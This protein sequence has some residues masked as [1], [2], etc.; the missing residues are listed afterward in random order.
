[1]G[2]PTAPV[3]Y[4]W[5]VERFPRLRQSRLSDFDN[6]ALFSL[7]EVTR[8]EG[9]SSHPAARGQVVHRTIARTLREMVAAG[10]DR[11]NVDVA[12][13]YLEQE[14]AQR[15]VAIEPR[16][17]SE[18]SD[19][20][21]LPLSQ[22]AE[23]RITIK[24]WAA[25]TRYTVESF[26][27]IEKRLETTLWY[28]ASPGNPDGPTDKAREDDPDSGEV[29][30]RLVTGQLDLLE[31]EDDEA[32]VV[33]WKDTWD[34]PPE[35]K[36]SEEGYFQQ[37]MYALLVF[38]RYPRVQRVTLREFYLRYASGTVLDRKNQPIKPV[39]EATVDRFNLG[40]IE[41]E[42]RALVERFD[43]SYEHGE[44]LAR[45]A[46]DDPDRARRRAFTPSP[47]SH[48]YY[49]KGARECPIPARARGD[50]R[51]ESP[52][53]A[54]RAAGALNVAR[55]VAKQIGS[56]LRAY[57]NVRGN[58]PVK[59]AKR[60]RVY[61]PVVRQRVQKPELGDV[62]AAARRG[63]DALAALYRP[64]EHVEF[65][66]HAPEEEHPFAKEARIEEEMLLAAE[67]RRGGKK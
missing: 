19:V 42:M 55:S 13:E 32:T 59:D 27:G 5:A 3:P 58:V 46:D 7:F 43:R 31:I 44:M 1:M 8:A 34:I 54:E 37:R 52:E 15:H 47:G 62:R 22:I 64:Q 63:D 24:T 30:T 60:P 29:V 40:E 10:E 67:K 4:P 6:C 50:G 9:W 35:S 41:A 26:A 36:I 53:D 20:V 39:R 56:A 28:P 49:C 61:G 57:S 12:L 2:A 48:C 38:H 66:V 14:L 25:N 17:G 45:K 11:P 16:F 33:D 23:A 51:I 65:T 18:D 21:N